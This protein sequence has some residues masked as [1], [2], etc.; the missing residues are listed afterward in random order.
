M[1]ILNILDNDLWGDTEV[2]QSYYTIRYYN[3]SGFGVEQ[4]WT[5]VPAA[6]EED[7]KE[8]AQGSYRIA[9]GLMYRLCAFKQASRIF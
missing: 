2:E 8:Q 7:A 5:N 4:E 9:Q 6:S 3:P 1:N